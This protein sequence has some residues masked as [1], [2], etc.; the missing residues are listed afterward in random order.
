MEF[1]KM[2][3]KQKVERVEK[4]KKEHETSL[5]CEVRSQEF[6]KET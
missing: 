3:K 4:R 2:M 1:N 5:E 6:W